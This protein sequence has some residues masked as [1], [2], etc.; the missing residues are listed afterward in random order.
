MADNKSHLLIATGI[1]LILSDIVPTPADALYFNLQQKWK[2]QAEDGLITPK[3]F[4]TKD[5]LAYYGLN[6]IWWALVLGTS[7]AIG[8]TFEQKAGIFVAVLSGGAIFGVIN[9]NIQKDIQRQQG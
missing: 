1:G 3:E 2:A 9:K 7:L 8:K 6:P 4:W 5:A